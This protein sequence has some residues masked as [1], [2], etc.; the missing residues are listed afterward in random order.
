MCGFGVEHPLLDLHAG[1]LES[2]LVPD[3]P[4]RLPGRGVRIVGILHESPATPRPIEHNSH[5]RTSRCDGQLPVSPA[6][7]SEVPV[8][9]LPVADVNDE[10]EQLS[11]FD[12]IDDSVVAGPDPIEINLP[13]EL[14]AD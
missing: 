5:Y 11:V 2:V 1:A 4:L 13:L 8:H 10:D 12:L 6:A 7:T 9:V 3:R 14:G